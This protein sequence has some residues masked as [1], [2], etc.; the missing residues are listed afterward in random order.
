MYVVLGYPILRRAVNDKM[1]CGTDGSG[2]CAEMRDRALRELSR[3]FSW[4][5][6]IP[7]GTLRLTKRRTRL[8]L[9]LGK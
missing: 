5:E 9:I 3:I 1:S 8:E 6:G 7:R 4:T 2:G